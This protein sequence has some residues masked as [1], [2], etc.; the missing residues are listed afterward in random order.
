[1][2]TRVAHGKL[3]RC[4]SFEHASPLH[5]RP[6]SPSLS[7][8]ANCVYMRIVCVDGASQMRR[9]SKASACSSPIS[10]STDT[11]S[12][13]FGIALGAHLPREM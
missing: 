2:F 10:S 6:W 9:G 5:R 4:A 13:S 12:R 11:S 7:I 8:K 3:V 1:M